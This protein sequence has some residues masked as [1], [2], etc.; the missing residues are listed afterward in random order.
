[1]LTATHGR[2][3]GKGSKNSPH[4]QQRT[5]VGIWRYQQHNIYYEVG[6]LK[7]MLNNVSYPNK[8]VGC[9]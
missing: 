8:P 5:R 7:A 3:C 2:R 9:F 4:C 1:M 6:K